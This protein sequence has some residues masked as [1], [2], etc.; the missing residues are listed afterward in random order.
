MDVPRK[1]FLIKIRQSRDLLRLGVAAL[2]SVAAA[3]VHYRL[4]AVQKALDSQ[5]VFH[6]LQFTVILIAALSIYR[7][8]ARFNKVMA[9]AIYLTGSILTA[10]LLNLHMSA[11]FDLFLLILPLPIYELQVYLSSGEKEQTLEFNRTISLIDNEI[12]S[13]LDFD[14]IMRRVVNEAAK[15]LSAESA[16]I[17]IEENGYWSGRYQVGLLFGAKARLTED[18]AKMAAFGK[19]LPQPEAVDDVY[20]DTRI[21]RNVIEK[22]RFRSLIAIPLKV[23]SQFIG[24]LTFNYHSHAISFTRAQR[25][26]ANK[27]ATTVSFALYNARLYNQE[28]RLSALSNTLN[29][30]NMEISSTFDVDEIMN[31]TITQAAEAIQCEAA[32]I[33]ML[34]KDDW[35]LRY[36]YGSLKKRVGSRFA[37]EEARHLVWATDIESPLLI[38]D[39]NNDSRINA[40]AAE[41]LGLKSILLVAL[42]PRKNTIGVLSFSSQSHTNAFTDIQVDFIRKTAVSLALAVEN[43]QLYGNKRNISDVLQKAILGLPK[44]TPGIEFSHLYHSATETAEVGGDFYDLFELENN[45]LAILIGDV[46]GKGLEAAALTVLV[47]NTLKVYAAE[48]DSPSRI[49]QK[50]HEMILRETSP[51]IFVTIFFGILDRDSLQLKYCGAGH[52]P[53]ILKRAS[54]EISVVSGNSP[55]AG[56]FP[57]IV[58]EEQLI[59]LKPGDCLVLYTDG[60]IESRR[61][62]RFFG[63]NRLIDAIKGS[64]SVGAMPN[65]IVDKVLDFTGNRLDDDLAILAV[66]LKEKALEAAA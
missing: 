1:P 8:I 16:A 42:A 24:V 63:Q 32:E 38:N 57:D 18:E 21:D 31:R 53:V 46:S 11:G 14:L 3:S 27:L 66:L 47:K 37:P 64:G 15:A 44:E 20:K 41:S 54:A 60:I 62:G 9:I 43:A 7:F 5:S 50:T 4:S 56:A 13:T 49:M 17:A 26:F 25:D 65:D 23:G 45:R 61:S 19:I 12:H 10:A 28:K 29:K 6:A 39:A 35:V 33:V 40:A 30:I 2:P 22:Y 59:A 55:V 36:K 51:G 48:Y 34:E 58:F 52:P